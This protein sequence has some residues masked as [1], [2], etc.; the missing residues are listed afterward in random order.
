MAIILFGLSSWAVAGP[1][2][3]DIE[4]CLPRLDS[5]AMRQNVSFPLIIDFVVGED[6][7]PHDL[8][9]LRS[10][11]SRV[12]IEDAFECI[13][14]WKL[15]GFKPGREFR[16]VLNWEH[17]IGWTSLGIQSGDY[18][19]RVR[20]N[21]NQYDCL[22]TR[23]AALVAAGPGTVSS[24]PGA[25]L[26]RVFRPEAECVRPSE[27][28]TEV[29]GGRSSLDVC[30]HGV[31]SPLY[32][33][34]TFQDRPEFL[35]L[36]GSE[37]LFPAF[38]GIGVRTLDEDFAR[39]WALHLHETEFSRRRGEFPGAYYPMEVH[40]TGVVR[41]EGLTSANGRPGCVLEI[42]EVES[43]RALTRVEVRALLE[44]AAPLLPRRTE[45]CEPA[46]TQAEWAD[47]AAGAEPLPVELSG[48][49]HEVVPVRCPWYPRGPLPGEVL[50]GSL[51]AL[52]RR[53]LLDLFAATGGANWSRTGAQEGHHGRWGGEAGTECAWFGVT[54]NRDQTAVEGIALNGNKL[55]GPIPASLGQLTALITL[56]LSENR[57]VGSVPGELAALPQ[58][59]TLDLE[60]NQLSG[61]IPAELAKLHCLETLYLSKNSLTGPIPGEL[62]RLQHLRYMHLEANSLSGP[63]PPEL[64]DAPDISRLLLAS[65]RLPGPVPGSLV[66][67]PLVDGQ[68]DI[69]WNALFSDDPELVDFL[70]AKQDGGDWESTQTV[71]PREIAVSA[72]SCGTRVAVSWTPIRYTA[73][74]GGY[75]VM[76]A[77]SPEGPFA[78]D[79]VA[80]GKTARGLTLTGLEPE[81]MYFIRVETWTDPHPNNPNSVVSEPSPTV[82]VLTA[83]PQGSTTTAR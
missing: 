74:E 69:R 71:A 19:H 83:R 39:S 32:N 4:F 79:G 53:T 14:G 2:E 28:C 52:E 81:T 20:L 36:G 75:R 23:E 44:A 15:G 10:F 24:D 58:L 21:L 73:D 9:L 55:S 40:G 62:A 50:G 6:G 61:P 60:S 77:R 41:S 76:V 12:Q 67:L 63:I 47:L 3:V 35:P 43:F 16:L 59:R 26:L 38:C 66:Q 17:G 11:H 27:A 33:R 54:C 30:L 8:R 65:N 13:Q 31:L 56:D 45:T 5:V 7:R 57:L 72:D 80:A 1:K 68:S 46:G 42:T 29:R 51:G 49:Q 37:D 78:V 70:N 82:P 25:V 18:S 34:H 48:P 22:P 64:G